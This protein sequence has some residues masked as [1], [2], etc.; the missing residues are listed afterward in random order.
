MLDALTTQ[1]KDGNCNSAVATCTLYVPNFGFASIE[2]INPHA[3]RRTS[4]RYER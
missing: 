1:N 2:G 4:N 3:S